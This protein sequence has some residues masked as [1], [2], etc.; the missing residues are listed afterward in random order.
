[1]CDFPTDN[2]YF[3][4]PG[5]SSFILKFTFNTRASDMRT[6]K[7]I[8]HLLENENLYMYINI[9]TALSKWEGHCARPLS[10]AEGRLSSLPGKDCAP[11][12]EEQ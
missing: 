3:N 11:G 2:S 1:M 4:I 10:C 6:F 5:V 12:F 9:F 8:N 7:V